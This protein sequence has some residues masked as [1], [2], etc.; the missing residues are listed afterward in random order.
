MLDDFKQAKA[1][2]TVFDGAPI[3]ICVI[4]LDG[5]LVDANSTLSRMLGFA[6]LEARVITTDLTDPRDV[7]RSIELFVDLAAGHFESFSIDKRY[8]RADG[9]TAHA[10]S[11][12]LLVRNADDE[13]DFV[14]GL[15]EPRDE[16]VHLRAEIS[17]AQ[18]A[19]HD[20]NNLLTAIFG[21]QELLLRALPPDDDRRG[22]VEAIGR[23]ARMS[24][25]IVQTILRTHTRHRESVDVNDLIVGMRSVAAQLVG[26]K[27]KIVLRLDPTIPPVVV[28][29]DL[30]ER[31]IAN[32]AANARD[33]MPDGG[34]F[35][36][37]TTADAAFVKI[38]MSDT[39]VGIQPGLRSR[40]FDRDFS[41]KSHGHGIGLALARETVEGARGFIRV[42]SDPGQGATFTLAF[43]RPST[44]AGSIRAEGEDSTHGGGQ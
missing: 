30:L 19:A 20:F 32:V 4:E 21:H 26:S 34:T 44:A 12:A 23:V 22:A 7:S 36:I 3:G 35:V 28:E 31:S 25:P 17:E 40:I 37:E 18:T 5:R 42:D 39:G 8:V 33:A 2:S 24:V 10:H 43:P 6:D 14:L 13:P 9:G 29:R 16:L 41:T 11:T 1:F 15:I 27:V 38:L